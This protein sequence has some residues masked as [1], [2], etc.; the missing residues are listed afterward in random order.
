MLLC[1]LKRLIDNN[2]QPTVS[3]LAGCYL[4]NHDSYRTCSRTT[5]MIVI[6]M[7]EIPFKIIHVYGLINAHQNINILAI[8]YHFIELF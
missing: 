6:I 1:P 7:N 4:W 3:P 8:L 2:L 5:M